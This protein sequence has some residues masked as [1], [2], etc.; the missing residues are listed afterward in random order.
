MIEGSPYNNN[1]IVDEVTAEAVGQAII[2]AK[3]DLVEEVHV[4]LVIY[5]SDLKYGDWVRILDSY[6]GVDTTQRIKKIT[7]SYNAQQG[8]SVGIEIG[9]PFDNYE[10]LIKDLTKGDVDE[11][12]EMSKQ[13]GALRLTAN[14]P[15]GNW[16]RHDPGQWYDTTG[17][18]QKKSKGA[19]PFWT[20]AD[21]PATGTYKK[22]L[23]Q[24]SNAG[25]VT[26]KVGTQETT[27]GAAEGTTVSADALNTPLGEVIL[28][29]KSG[30]VGNY[31]VEDVYS[32]DD[33]GKSYIYRD[34]RPIVG[35]SS[36]GIGGSSPWEVSGSYSQ[37]ITARAIDMQGY[38]ITNLADLKG[39]LNAD[40]SLHG[41]NSTD[42]ALVEFLQWDHSSEQIVVNRNIDLYDASTIS[43]R[44]KFRVPLSEGYTGF[45]VDYHSVD[46]LLRFRDATAGTSVMTLSDAGKLNLWDDLW[47][48]KGKEINFGSPNT[49]YIYQDA[50]TNDLKFY[51]TV[52]G[53]TK[54][55][56]ELVSGVEGLWEI[57][58]TET[59]LITADD[60]DMQ[61]YGFIGISSLKPSHVSGTTIFDVNGNLRGYLG[62]T[63]YAFDADADI[64]MGSS[65]KL[66]NLAAGAVNGDSIRY[67]EFH[68]HDIA[69]TGTHGVGANTIEHTGH[70]G[71]AS[72]YCGLDVDGYI[73]SVGILA[74]LTKGNLMVGSATVV[75]ALG[76][77]TNTHVLTV[78]STEALGMKWAANVSG[79]WEVSGIYAQL[80][81]AKAV[82]M[83]TNDIVKCSQI[84]GQ[85]TGTNG[86]DKLIVDFRGDNNHQIYYTGTTDNRLG[87]KTYYAHAFAIQA[88]TIAQIDQY[89]LIMQ[90]GKYIKSSSGDLELR[91]PSGS[92]IKFVIG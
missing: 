44:L 73:P 15:P 9:M 70:K 67:D 41:S 47:L 63:S 86:A 50:A 3:K 38:E 77:G 32:S 37:L 4:D 51:D 72:G 6:S 21:N 60:I 14:D 27:A 64:N 65:W 11:E 52:L 45:Y 43:P 90:T 12:P 28:K 33:A 16:I 56:S 29:G 23:I 59:Q 7:R 34:V 40:F 22:A 84:S 36:T 55:L 91:A 78:D 85:T 75:T 13:G 54:T 8:E 30:S 25:S 46:G 20:G 80:I 5:I 87:Y 69:T 19:V 10:M 26:Y 66:K 2:D 62:T 57:D 74:P 49:A 61:A 18:F 17:A 68:A 88:A 24:I 31:V 1:M 48:V 92:K 53:A 83:Q 76:A 58:G 42:D 35:S 39:S 89:G 71:A 82:D 81:A 79:I